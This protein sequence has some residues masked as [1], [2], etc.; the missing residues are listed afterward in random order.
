MTRKTLHMTLISL[1]YHISDRA[2]RSV[3]ED[4]IISDKYS[5]SSSEKGYAIIKNNED[6]KQAMEYLDKKSAAI[7][8]RKNCLLRNFQGYLTNQLE[9]FSNV[10]TL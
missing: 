5:I 8:V 7:A 4:M 6:L 2:L 10:T 9:I 1:G 3:I